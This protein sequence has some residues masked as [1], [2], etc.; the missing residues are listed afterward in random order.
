MDAVKRVIVNELGHTIPMIVTQDHRGVTVVASG[1]TSEVEH[2]WTPMEAE[3]LRDLLSEVI[4]R[5]R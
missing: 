4:E 5:T 1:P 3:T 2:T